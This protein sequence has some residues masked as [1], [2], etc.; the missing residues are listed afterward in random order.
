MRVHINRHVKP[1]GQSSRRLEDKAR[2]RNGG[3][4]MESLLPIKPLSISLILLG[5]SKRSCESPEGLK[6]CD[7]FFYAQ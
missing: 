4:I 1:S 7:S 6:L 3:Q 5:A 2:V